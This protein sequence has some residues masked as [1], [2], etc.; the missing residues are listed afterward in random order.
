[1]HNCL[2]E[3]HLTLPSFPVDKRL[4]F[5][6]AEADKSFNE[7]W[8]PIISKLNRAIYKGR[9]FLWH[10]EKVHY[11]EPYKASLNGVRWATREKKPRFAMLSMDQI[12][13]YYM[14]L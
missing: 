1:M 8:K 3:N 13:A 4:S 11:F 14:Q 5:L 2:T 9:V 10:G 12:Q 6:K 7:K